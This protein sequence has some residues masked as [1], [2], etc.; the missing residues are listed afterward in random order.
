M[1]IFKLILICSSWFSFINTTCRTDEDDIIRYR[2]YKDCKDRVFDSDEIED[3]AY[4]CCH[5]EIETETANVENSVEG[6]IPLNETEFNNIRQLIKFYESQ[7]NVDDVDID[8][9]SSYIKFSLISLVTF[10]L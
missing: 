10:F 2:N 7:P 4:K 6:C 5:I 8:C 1:N 9:K 3:N